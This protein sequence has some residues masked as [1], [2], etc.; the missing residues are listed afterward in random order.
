MNAKE[1]RDLPAGELT[2]KLAGFRE[3]IFN[4]KFKATTEP[5]D[6]PGRVRAMKKDIA[7]ALTIQRER[8]LAGKPRPKKLT[9]AKRQAARE[10]TARMAELKAAKERKAAAR[11]RKPATAKKG[12]TTKTAPPEAPKA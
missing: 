10:Q 3:E 7:R 2:E 11:T 4:L 6:N 8:E 5:I 12:T 1:I 9:R